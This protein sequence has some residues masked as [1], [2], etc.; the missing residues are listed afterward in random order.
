MLVTNQNLQDV[1]QSYARA[2]LTPGE[3]AAGANAGRVPAPPK[4]DAIELS[5][6]TL[7]LQKA[8]AILRSSPEVRQD[9]VA[10]LRHD[11]NAGTFRVR[12][13]EIASQLCLVI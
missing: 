8:L 7:E 9:L 2:S 3:S 5:A 13:D 1:L 6:G 10:A 4:R 12:P 11:I